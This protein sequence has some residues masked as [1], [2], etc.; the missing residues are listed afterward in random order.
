MVPVTDK[1]YCL[2]VK[3]HIL[4]P[5]SLI[6][7]SVSLSSWIY[8]PCVADSG[9]LYS[10]QAHELEPKF[11]YIKRISAEIHPSELLSW[12]RSSSCG[13]MPETSWTQVREN[14]KYL[15][16]NLIYYN[17]IKFNVYL[18]TVILILVHTEI[19]KQINTWKGKITIECLTFST[20]CL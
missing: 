15:F 19:M 13:P 12:H 14:A 20:Q 8:E 4:L 16:T 1:T 3:H 2:P 18:Y 5:P 17:L 11:T 6:L 7:H 9:L 10:A